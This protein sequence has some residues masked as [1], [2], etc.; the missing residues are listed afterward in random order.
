[1]STAQ[2]TGIASLIP[3][4]EQGYCVL[5]PNQR[6][7]DAVLSGYGK[8]Q[9]DN[10]W[11]TPDVNA[12][13]IWIADFWQRLG[14]RG[15]DPFAGQRL[16]GSNEETFLWLEII[17]Q[18]QQDNPLLNT[19][20]AAASAQRAYRLFRLWL[21][22]HDGEI[23]DATAVTL[24]P[25]A[26]VPELNQFRDWARQFLEMCRSR[27]VV[28][29]ADATGILLRALESA[30]VSP[31]E[32]IILVNFYQP[33]PLYARLFN[34]LSRGQHNQVIETARPATGFILS[35]LIHCF[36]NFEN[37]CQACA[38]WAARLAGAH[39]EQQIGIVFDGNHDQ[40]RTLERIFRD[41]FQPFSLLD[42]A[43]APAPFKRSNGETAISDCGLISEALLILNL[44]DGELDSADVCRLLQSPGLVAWE[45]EREAR[46]HLETQLRDNL[47]SN[48]SLSQLLRIM[49][50]EHRPYHCP[51][52]S[53]ALLQ[54]G[55]QIRA[56]RRP[57]SAAE[58]ADFFNRQLET[59]GWPG[60]A[61]VEDRQQQDLLKQWQ[62]TLAEFAA[63]SALLGP[64]DRGRAL[65]RFRALCQ[66][67]RLRIHYDPKCQVSLVG[68]NDAA[69]LEFDHA[70]CLNFSDQVQ[71]PA[72]QPSPFLLH[73]AQ[74]QAR[75]P[76]S[77]ARIQLEYA[78]QAFDIL[79]RSV[80]GELHGSFHTRDGDEQFRASSLLDSFAAA[81]ITAVTHS[82]LNRMALSLAGR[83]IGTAPSEPGLPLSAGEQP[84]GGQAL[85]SD[86]SSCPFRA[87]ASHRLRARP[88]ET[89][90]SGLNARARGTALHIALEQ[91]FSQLQSLAQLRAISATDRDGLVGHCVGQALEFLSRRFPELMTPRFSAIE[92]DRLGALLTG[93][94]ELEKQ[95]GDFQVIA[96]EQEVTWHYRDLQIALKIDRVDRLADGT[97]AVIDYKT[98]R[99]TPRPAS[100]LEP[101]PESLQLPVYQAAASIELDE[102]VEA[103]V[104]ARLHVANTGYAG[105]SATDGFHSDLKPVQELKDFQQDWESLTADWTRRL[106]QFADEFIDGVIRVDPAHGTNTCR[107]CR[108][109]PLC[110]IHELEPLQ[111]LS[112]DEGRE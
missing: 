80:A 48:C 96:T 46:I 3:Y 67:T 74:Q 24:P 82:F 84:G 11:V 18:S 13:D 28:S 99:T 97:L 52:L 50:R 34:L 110:R 70:W 61:A 73:S 14:S 33:P 41:V 105:L 23:S 108:L 58:W 62:R 107:Y 111:E 8:H 5:V 2:E 55:N 47:S 59:L 36:D 83:P 6:I 22:R 57:R 7:R 4:L 106:E 69:G 30:S 37:E 12:I 39:P 86:Q 25:A 91:L 20:E 35:G 79:A 75:I 44:D 60:T 109:Q 104:I 88:L 66:V 19:G 43:S 98:G 40:L 94:L 100:L 29:L 49:S 92:R 72:P 77:H 32:R 112:A 54:L 27:Q 31:P 21:D 51:R 102:T 76:G 64:M 95:R 15:R 45:E 17:E 85:L 65:S 10:C 89:F 81:P 9:P 87:F 68:L 93:Y 1:M 42:P 63:M 26:G 101:R 56:N 78:R 71:P 103:V 16:L 90:D 38:D 53:A